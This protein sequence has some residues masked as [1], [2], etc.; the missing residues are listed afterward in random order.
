M[1]SFVVRSAPNRSSF[2]RHRSSFARHSIVRT[3]DERR[4]IAIQA[5]AERQ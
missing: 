5:N 1:L 2:G 3:F 4:T